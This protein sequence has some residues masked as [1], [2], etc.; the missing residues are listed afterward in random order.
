MI[1]RTMQE[2]Y[3]TI[4]NIYAPKIGTPKY[5][6]QILTDIKGETDS[7]AIII[8]RDFNNQLTSMNRSSR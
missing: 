4:V 7:I 3:I 1:K 6:K 8:V 2:E 5:T